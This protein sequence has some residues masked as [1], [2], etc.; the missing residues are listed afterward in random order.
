MTSDQAKP[1]KPPCD[2]LCER[3][4]QYLDGD[5]PA[6]LCAQVA[7][8]VAACTRCRALHDDLAALIRCCAESA[9]E[10]GAV[11]VPKEVHD[12]LWAVLDAELRRREGR[13]NEA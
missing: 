4:S 1:S 3:L 6:E 11:R 12:A 9:A 7:A 10:P 8:H 2:P 13:A 5:L